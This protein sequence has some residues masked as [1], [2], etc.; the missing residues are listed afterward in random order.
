MRLSLVTTTAL[1]TGLTLFAGTPLRVFS[2]EWYLSPTQTVYI[3]KFSAYH[4][5]RQSLSLAMIR[6][7]EWN[8]AIVD[9]NLSAI[10][11]MAEKNA[12]HGLLEHIKD[13][14]NVRRTL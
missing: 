9:G 6:E 8:M 14:K 3:K 13:H 12:T 1:S 5:G 4:G 7:E 11:A 2:S 10:K